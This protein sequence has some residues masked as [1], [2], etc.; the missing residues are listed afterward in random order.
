MNK[1]LTITLLTF[2]LLSYAGEE[3]SF[4]TGIQL[5][6]ASTLTNEKSLDFNATIQGYDQAVRVKPNEPGAAL[7]KATGRPY[8]EIRGWIKE[9]SIFLVNGNGN[10]YDQWVT[11]SNFTT[12]GDLSPYGYGRFDS[13]GE[14]NNIRVGGTAYIR[15]YNVQGHYKGTATFRLCHL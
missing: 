13:N 7:F 15:S 2:P 1:L 9:S 10:K 4:R 3:Q 12:G 11:V 6:E 14:L 8:G 5:L